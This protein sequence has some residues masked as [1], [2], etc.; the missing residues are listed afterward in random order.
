MVVLDPEVVNDL[1]KVA[2]FFFHFLVMA[3]ALFCLPGADEKGHAFEDLIHPSEVAVD[4]MA[5]V[6][7]EKPMISLV[8]LLQPVTV[9]LV[10]HRD[11]LR[12]L[13]L[14]PPGLWALRLTLLLLSPAVGFLRR[15]TYILLLG[16][17]GY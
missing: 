7:L 5:V 11:A 15:R 4:E 9:P 3:P 13:P 12:L 6:Y 17:G 16:E 1:Q 2:I 8:L 10:L 14:L